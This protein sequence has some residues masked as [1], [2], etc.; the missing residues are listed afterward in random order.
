MPGTRMAK[1]VIM[2]ETGK[3]IRATRCRWSYA[4]TTCAQQQLDEGKHPEKK[5]V[6]LLRGLQKLLVRL[7]MSNAET[8]ACVRQG[9]RFGAKQFAIL[10]RHLPC[11]ARRWR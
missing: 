10:G 8:I 2:R 7:E 5:V 4:S 11:R 1:D 9:S 6:D 3:R